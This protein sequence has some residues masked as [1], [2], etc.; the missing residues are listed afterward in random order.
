M[1]FE[2]SEELDELLLSWEDNDLSEADAARLHELL[3]TNEAARRQFATHQMLTAA[4][5]L[6]GDRAGSPATTPTAVV[7]PRE[8]RKG[9][10]GVI[11]AAAA[12]C[13]LIG[14]LAYLEAT[15]GAADRQPAGVTSA[16]AIASQDKQEPTSR[17]IAVVSRAVDVSWN[18]ETKPLAIGDPIEPGL[19]S[20]DAGLLQIEFF[21]GATVVLQGPASL[22]VESS[23]RARLVAGRLRAAV[24]PAA[25]GFTIDVDEL[26]VVDLGTEF[27]LAVSGDATE[28]QVFDGEVRIEDPES[29]HRVLSAGQAV[30]RS[31][32][33]AFE[34]T[35]ATP[36]T[37]VDVSEV[38][39]Q[40]HKRRDDRFAKWQSASERYREDKRLIA[41]FTFSQQDTWNRKLHSSLDPDDK[42]LDGAIVGAT[43]TTG[44]WSRK[45]ALEFKRPADR[46]RLQIPGEFGALTLACW[47]RID[48][49]DRWY[50]SLF[51]T[52]G[53]EPGEPHWQ[54]LDTGQLFFSVRAR[55][56]GDPG[57]HHKVVLSEP[58]WNA[59]MSGRWFHLA[60]V[61]D[62]EQATV[63]HYIN[64]RQITREAIPERLLQKKTRI[65][66][67]SLGNWAAPTKPDEAFAIRNLNGRMDEFM[68]FGAALNE[69]EIQ[70]IYSYGK[71]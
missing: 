9:R 53:Y 12:A 67:A 68:L 42:E 17:G 18:A 27:G 8:D 41:W 69:A 33:G 34:D 23:L 52:D 22:D 38:Q 47:V 61:L 50:N 2:R 16:P 19:L 57:P 65:G 1:N 30:T 39:S 21:C 29:G 70:E 43:W 59:S 11:A 7:H 3:K 13:V 64:G 37:F 62:S 54:I 6:E 46:V 15:R 32:R 5:R 58:F 14:R 55:P 4:L 20:V 51:L 40:V 10:F 71:P 26:Q 66:T 63:T 36:N 45:N 48:S 60:T 28:V 35:G 49:L 24:P 31:A 56:D 25:R 44:R